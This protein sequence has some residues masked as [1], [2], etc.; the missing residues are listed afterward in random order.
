[1]SKAG[2]YAELGSKTA[3]LCAGLQASADAAGIALTTQSVGAMFGLFFTDQDSVSTFEQVMAC[4]TQRFARFFHAM[5]AA[6]VNLAP[7]AFEAGF[8]SA[9]HSQQD[10]QETI[11]AASVAFAGL[12]DN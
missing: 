4:D 7:S 6:G 5:L 2:F 1:M 9:A 11:D 3:Q 12:S 10:I 8:I